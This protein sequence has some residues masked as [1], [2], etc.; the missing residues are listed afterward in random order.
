MEKAA[1]YL[2]YINTYCTVVYIGLNEWFN[3]VCLV[4]RVLKT[5]LGK[6]ATLYWYPETTTEINYG[7][8]TLR[9]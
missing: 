8:L 1:G 2:L 6:L 3:R 4:S 9:K 7:S 5:F